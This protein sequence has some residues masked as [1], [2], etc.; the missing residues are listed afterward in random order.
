MAGCKLRTSGVG[1]NS[2]TNWAS[3]TIKCWLHANVLLNGQQL[4]HIYIRGSALESS[5]GQFWRKSFLLSVLRRRKQKKNSGSGSTNGHLNSDTIVRHFKL[6]PDSIC[7]RCRHIKFNVSLNQPLKCSGSN[8][9]KMESGETNVKVKKTLNA[10]LMGC[11]LV[12]V[13]RLGEFWKSL[14]ANFITKVAQIFGKL[15]G[16]LE[17]HRF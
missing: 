12:S 17:K 14:T 5:H 10:L 3:T 13:T 2:S 4:W 16:H 9:F 7:H 8:P 1:S 15:F 6:K 11:H